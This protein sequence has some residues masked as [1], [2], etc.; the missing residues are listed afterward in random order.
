M[1]HLG[2]IFLEL[3]SHRLEAQHDLYQV[4]YFESIERLSMNDIKA[5]LKN[6]V[7]EN[8]KHSRIVINRWNNGDD[9]LGLRDGGF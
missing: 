8:D 4:A 6:I 1:T 2:P 3:K 7:Q 5:G 9:N